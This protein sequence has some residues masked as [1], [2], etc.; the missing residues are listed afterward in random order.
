[1]AFLRINEHTYVID[2]SCVLHC[3]VICKLLENIHSLQSTILWYFT[4]RQ[5]KFQAIYL[6]TEY[7]TFSL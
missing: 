4:I 6:Y 7:V 1:M 2:A 5:I 3:A